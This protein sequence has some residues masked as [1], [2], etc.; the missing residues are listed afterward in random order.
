MHYA[1]YHQQVSYE[2]SSFKVGTTIMI[3]MNKY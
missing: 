1:I 3:V 2:F